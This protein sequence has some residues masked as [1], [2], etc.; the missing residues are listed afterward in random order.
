VAPH[1]GNAI[2]AVEFANLFI[3]PIVAGNET[4]RT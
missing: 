2:S 4:T 1:D 3:Q